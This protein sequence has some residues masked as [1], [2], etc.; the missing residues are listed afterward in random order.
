MHNYYFRAVLNCNTCKSFEEVK[1][2][3]ERFKAVYKGYLYTVLVEG[4]SPGAL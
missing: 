4:V 1:K 3:L 2:R